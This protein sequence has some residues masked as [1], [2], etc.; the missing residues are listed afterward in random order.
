MKQLQEQFYKLQHDLDKGSQEQK[1]L[2]DQLKQG[3]THDRENVETPAHK[4]EAKE[5]ES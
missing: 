2:K 4:Q 1:N 5:Y 3:R